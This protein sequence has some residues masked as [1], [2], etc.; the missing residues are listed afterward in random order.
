VKRAILTAL[1]ITCFVAA[2]MA[3]DHRQPPTVGE[4]SG[5]SPVRTDMVQSEAAVVRCAHVTGYYYYSGNFDSANLN[6]N[7]L[8]N[9]ADKIV[10]TGSQVYQPFSVKIKSTNKHLSVTGLCENSL[11]T[12]GLGI[13]NPTPYEVRAK[14]MVGSGGTLV[15][16]G[17]VT[18]SDVATGRSGFGITEYTHAVKISKCKLAGSTNAGT[19]YHMN[20]TPQCF[21]NS[22]CG[23]ARYFESTDDANLGHVGPPTNRSAALWNSTFFGENSVNPNTVFGGQMMESFS[24]GVTGRLVK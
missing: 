21:K 6:A 24:A 17:T 2:G 9:E 11:D 20:V 22:F 8:S 23:S 3:V 16:H 12:A 5:L 18:S 1:L 7:G 4:Y 19:Q 15:C 14:A 10:N 13:D